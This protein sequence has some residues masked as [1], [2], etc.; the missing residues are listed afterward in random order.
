MKRFICLALLACSSA[1]VITNACS[2]TRAMGIRNNNEI[3]I[4]QWKPHVNETMKGMVLLC[5]EVCDIQGIQNTLDSRKLE[6]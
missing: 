4:V 5:K 3:L 6:I 2:V 1:P